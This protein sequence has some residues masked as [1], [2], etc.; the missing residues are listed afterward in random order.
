MD[1]GLVSRTICVQQDDPNTPLAGKYYSY[2][3]E[4][5]ELSTG[6]T[7][8]VQGTS[9]TKTATVSPF[10]TSFDIHISCS[11]DF[12]GGFGKKDGPKAG[13]DAK[14]LSYTIWKYDV[15]KKTGDCEFKGSCSSVLTS[16][17]QPDD[18]NVP[19]TEKYY[20]YVF[21]FEQLSTGN[22]IVVQA[23]SPSKTAMV[24]PFGT[25]FDIHISCSDPFTG[26]FGTKDGPTLSDD[27]KV[28]SYTIWK[29]DFDKDGNCEFKGSCTGSLTKAANLE[30]VILDDEVLLYPNP[31]QNVLSIV[32]ELDNNSEVSIVIF[33]LAGRQ[34]ALV[35]SGVQISGKNIVEWNASELIQGTYICRMILG[36]K[37]YVEKFIVVK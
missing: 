13:D 10:G 6:N 25:S 1:A 19:Q 11:D 16:C 28:L 35:Q 29:Y 8:V 30:S 3:F 22:T 21:E 17:V 26:G 18:P 9:P 27:A 24:N 31:V 34:I 7:I 15:D 12:P 37:V 23:T 36:N 32:Y 4:F 2:E 33:D 5:E 14:V 20:S